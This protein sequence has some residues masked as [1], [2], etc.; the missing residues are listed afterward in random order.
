MNVTY[1]IIDADGH[2]LEKD[3]ELHDYLGG[4]YSQ[5]A[6]LR[7]LFLFSFPRRLEPRHRRAGQRSGN[8]RA[9]LAAISRRAR[10]PY[11]GALPNRWIG[12]RLGA[13][14]GV[15]L[16]ARA[17]VQLVACRPLL[18]CQP[19]PQRRRAA[20]GA[21][22]RRS[23]QRTRAGES[24]WDLVAGLL[25]AVTGCTRATATPISIRSTKRPSG[26]ICR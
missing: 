22:T 14:S 15:G 23:R 10:R 26:S 25:P 3:R 16:R 5:R 12:T 11:H 21:R 20:A 9:A 7:N 4:R 1:P 13:K 19:A 6:P 18:Q 17:R 8:S 2:V 24:H